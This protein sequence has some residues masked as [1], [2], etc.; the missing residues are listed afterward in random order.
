MIVVCATTTAA[1]VA[2]EQGRSL[3]YGL[4]GWIAPLLPI[5]LLLPY[6]KKRRAELLG[7]ERSAQSHEGHPR[8]I[9]LGDANQFLSYRANSKAKVDAQVAL[10]DALLTRP[11]APPV[12]SVLLRSADAT[13]EFP[14]L[15]VKSG[16]HKSIADMRNY[17]GFEPTFKELFGDQ[18]FSIVWAD[19]IAENCPGPGEA[20]T[21]LGRERYTQLARDVLEANMSWTASSVRRNRSPS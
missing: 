20:V 13:H 3:W 19:H 9:T 15:I 17:D 2:R 16:T 7:I 8:S 14:W 21:P 5:I 6:T 11:D 10:M 4:A 18:Q 12:K 1:L